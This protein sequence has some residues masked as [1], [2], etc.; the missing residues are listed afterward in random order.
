MGLNDNHPF[1]K[2]RLLSSFRF[3][4]QGLSAVIKKEKNVKIHLLAA[5]I[6]VIASF[7]LRISA[8]EWMF[9]L[10]CIFGMLSLE[11]INSALEKTVDLVTEDFHPLAKY[12]KDVSAAAVLLYALMTVIIGCVIFLPKLI[13]LFRSLI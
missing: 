7:L 6:V 4:L 9:I 2:K 11:L 12:A 5:V 8:L 13:S 10:F 3:A 1:N